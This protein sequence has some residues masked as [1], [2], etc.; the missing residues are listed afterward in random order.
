MKKLYKISNQLKLH[1]KVL[2]PTQLGPIKC[3]FKCCQSTIIPYTVQKLYIPTAGFLIQN[4]NSISSFQNL[5]LMQSTIE[6]LKFSHRSKYNTINKFVETGKALVF[7]NV[8]YNLDFA[9]AVE[10]YRQHL[11]EYEIQV[12]DE[13]SSNYL[14]EDMVK[15]YEEH[16][17]NLE[18]SVSES[19][20]KG[21]IYI[22][23]TK[24]V[25]VVGDERVSIIGKENINRAINGNA[26]YVEIFTQECENQPEMLGKIVGIRNQ[27]VKECV[28][29]VLEDSIVDNQWGL[30]KSIDSALPLC[31]LYYDDISKLLG[32]RIVYFITGWDRK[33]MY[34]TARVIRTLGPTGERMSEIQA[35]LINYETPT[36]STYFTPAMFAS[37]NIS[38]KCKETEQLYKRLEQIK[39]SFIG[40]Q[41]NEE[42]HSEVSSLMEKYA[43]LLFDTSS[44]TDLTNDFIFSIDPP[45]CT[46]ID[47]ALSF[48]IEGANYLVGIHIADVSHY[49]ERDSFI[50]KE[51]AK[52]GN[53]V[54]IDTRIEMLP[55]YLSSNL[56]SL[57]CS[58][59][60]LA[61]SIFIVIDKSLK[62]VSSKVVQSVINPRFSFTYEQAERILMGG[63]AQSIGKYEGTY[64]P[65]EDYEKC[66]NKNEVRDTLQGMNELAKR[67][68]AKRYENGSIDLVT[69][70]SLNTN[71]LVG[72][73]MLLANI[74]VSRILL[75][76]G[77][78]SLLR[79][80]PKIT[81]LEE[82]ASILGGNLSDILERLKTA[83]R[84]GNIELNRVLS[85]LI[86][87]VDNKVVKLMIIR[88][89]NQAVYFCSDSSDSNDHWHFG[90]SVPC[91]THFTSPIR[92]YA[93]MIV[94]RMLKRLLTS[95]EL[96]CDG[97][98]KI[99][100]SEEIRLDFQSNYVLPYNQEELNTITARIN[101]TNRFARMA[102]WDVEKLLIYYD[103][104]EGTYLATIMK[105]K[106]GLVL[107]YIDEFNLQETVSCD[108]PFSQLQNVLVR[109]FKDDNFFFKEKRLPIEIIN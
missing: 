74:A 75:R 37:T 59:K 102:S 35:I 71:R 23:G 58:E 50:D 62:I 90:L 48:K 46:D 18:F 106:D 60:K 103:L 44:R 20:R 99:V 5:L 54:Y 1:T 3:N 63:K 42:T 10:F 101:Q 55:Q 39:E 70:D 83:D 61:M 68:R 51:A 25:V 31:R 24:G 84:M 66:T 76:S 80:H 7:N 19:I 64:I 12:S 41:F 9:P 98:F 2:I 6:E 28:G 89:M 49:V 85:D 104:K 52:R 53:T 38:R 43:N 69:E 17:T 11:P 86:N 56:C 108:L 16:L 100:N 97:N 94:H 26:V 57:R 77:T 78:T 21:V 88:Q 67:L 91:Y 47:D 32:R 82:V 107:L 73:Y 40:D 96:H 29:S 15:D 36:T 72:E 4:C 109:V 45:G 79:R 81:N 87:P 13:Y 22:E 33:A 30:L 8:A 105:A 93:D 92:R 34:P 14:H 27:K 65:N 95:G